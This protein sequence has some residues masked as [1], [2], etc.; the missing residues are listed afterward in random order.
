MWRKEASKSKTY[1]GKKKHPNS[2][3]VS[4]KPAHSALQANLLRQVTRKQKF[5]V[6]HNIGYEWTC[7]TCKEK[8]ILKVYAGETGRSARTR[9]AE[10][11][12]E[13]EGKK[14]K[15]VL[16]KLTTKKNFSRGCYLDV[17]F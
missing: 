3:N 9:G 17:T 1:W 4:K 11:V 10:H 16:S 8:N 14:T 6:T 2:Q 13:L 12:K 5:L 15:S 7:L